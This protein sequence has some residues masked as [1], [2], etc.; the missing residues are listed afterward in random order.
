MANT[1]GLTSPSPR[2]PRDPQV[3]VAADHLNAA[4]RNAVTS[5][6]RAR[7]FALRAIVCG[8]ERSSLGAALRAWRVGV[9]LASTDLALSSQMA[10]SMTERSAACDA[11]VAA[12]TTAATASAAA[13]AAAAA[14][15]HARELSELRARL[16]NERE[17][18]AAAAAAEASAR[19]EAA[20]AEA[21]AAAAARV[22]AA[23]AAARE[24]QAEAEAR[25]AVAAATTTVATHDGGGG[26]GGP[27]GAA[28]PPPPL[29]VRATDS[30]AL[31]LV[32]SAAI[33]ACLRGVMRTPEHSG[34]AMCLERWRT[35]ATAAW[36]CRSG[37]SP[38]VTMLEV[39]HRWQWCACA[40]SVPPAALLQMGFDR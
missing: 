33:G 15:V 17:E 16:E 29:S 5:R 9:A 40:A 36:V 23:E 22:A 14:E 37:A 10:Q 8:A 21:A 1:P 35:C 32:R 20:A 4:V 28:P 19:A 11:A 6:E 30:G 2:L 12:A 3:G 24:A 7:P 25:A 26:E 27:G 31:A 13:A 38:R 39:V 34:L 18:A